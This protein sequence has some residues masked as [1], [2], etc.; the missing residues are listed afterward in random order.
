MKLIIQIPCY[1]EAA[2]IGVT[3]K[4]LPRELDGCGR[5]E[6]LV[7]DDGSTDGTAEAARAC[8]ADHVVRLPKNGGL[9]RAFTAGLEACLRLGADII[10]NTD[11]DNQY[12][13]GDIAA[14]V[15]P[16]REGRADIVVGARP[17]TQT[18]HF[19]P[20]KK[21]LQ[22]AG[23]W[24]VRLASRTDLPDAPSGFR[25]MSREA[26]MRLNVFSSYTY[27]LETIIQ[28]GQ[29]G[30][31][32]V[33]VPVRTNAPL[34]PSRLLK[35]VA[36]Y[37][38]RSFLTIVR[39]FVVYKPFW[40]FVIVGVALFSAGVFLGARFIYYAYIVQDHTQRIQSLIL[41]AILMGMGFQTM[42]TAFLA[43]LLSVN[44]RLLEDLQYR[45]KDSGRGR[46]GADGA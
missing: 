17:I 26:A 27:T 18:E 11:A 34:R 3:L 30:M 5:V 12:Q 46:G 22:L 35:S 7:I 32:I 36:S 23:S 10:V 21:L 33:S 9:A 6:W 42:L 16:V 2:F 38:W 4:A 8:G 13:A 44:R 25:A 28:A 37:V 15:A 39:I 24:V 45:A 19:S 29:K 14:L 43:D 41:A 1:N 31:A 40:S 20:A